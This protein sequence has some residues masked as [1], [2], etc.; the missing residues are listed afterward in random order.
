MSLEW[1]KIQ[2]LIDDKPA[3]KPPLKKKSKTK[4]KEKVFEQF[5]DEN[6]QPEEPELNSGK[7]VKTEDMPQ[8]LKTNK[9]FNKS[10][11]KPYKSKY[12]YELNS[13]SQAY[14]R[15]GSHKDKQNN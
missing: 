15:K 1:N 9:S 7:N 4:K 14:E 11:K 3:P 2:Q 5:Y 10:H 12:K 8:K 13:S 6:D